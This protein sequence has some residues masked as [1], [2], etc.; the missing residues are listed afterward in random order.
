MANHFNPAALFELSQGIGVHGHTADFFNITARGRLPVG[1]D[2]KRFHH[3]T[4][5]LRR[6]FFRKPDEILA[7]LRCTLKTPALRRFKKAQAPVLPEKGKLTH[8]RQ[9]SVLRIAVF[10][11][12]GELSRAERPGA[13]QKRSFDHKP[14][15]ICR[16]HENKRLRLRRAQCL[17]TK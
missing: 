17:L 16:I 11:Q 7:D 9:D 15:I 13:R 14:G 2:R 6:L 5:V 1:N 10:K 4:R 3:R 12:A 8:L